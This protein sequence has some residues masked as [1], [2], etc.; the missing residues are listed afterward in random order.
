[1]RSLLV[2]IQKDLLVLPAL[3]NGIRSR[4]PTTTYANTLFNL[5]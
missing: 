5:Q 4:V 1:V 2:I 3:M